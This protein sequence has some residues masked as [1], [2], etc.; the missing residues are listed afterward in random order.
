MC[1]DAA[2]Q[3][4]E[5]I[6]LSNLSDAWESGVQCGQRGVLTQQPPVM[7]RSGSKRGGHGTAHHVG[8]DRAGNSNAEARWRACN[9][10]GD[11][12]HPTI[13]ADGNRADKTVSIPTIDQVI[14]RAPKQLERTS[15][16]YLFC[17]LYSEIN[18]HHRRTK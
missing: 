4:S 7:I 8:V 16:V 9:E 10:L 13:S 3:S 14:T 2:D 18:T 15:D 17:K 11:E 6:Q 1:A 5:N 12:R